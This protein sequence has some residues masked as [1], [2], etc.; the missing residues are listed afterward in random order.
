[1]TNVAT[2]VVNLDTPYGVVVKRTDV[3]LFESND[4]TDN[5]QNVQRT[6]DQLVASSF[7]ELYRKHICKHNLKN[8]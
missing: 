6:A 1:M 8:Q 4:V 7:L 2:I 5:M 3:P